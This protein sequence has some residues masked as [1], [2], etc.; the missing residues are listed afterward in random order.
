MKILIVDDEVVIRKGIAALLVK[1]NS[2][3]DL[4]GEAKNGKEAIALIEAEQPDLIFTDIRMPVMDGLSLMEYVSSHYPKIDKVLLT[5]YADFQY[6]QHAIRLGVMDYI[7]KP[8]TQESIDGVLSKALFKNPAQWAEQLDTDVVVE[9]SRHIAQLARQVLAEHAGEA[10]NNLEEW[11]SK[12]ERWGLSLTELK[13]LMGHFRLMYQSELHHL[14]QEPVRHTESR[15]PQS[16]QELFEQWNAQIQ[17]HIGTISLNRVPRNKKIVAQVLQEIEQQYG[18][19][20]LSIHTLA[21]RAGV[22]APYLSKMFREIMH[23]PLTHYISE[24]R[25]EKVKERLQS[26]MNTRISKISEECGFIDYPYF[27]KTF[28]KAYNVSP[29]EYREKH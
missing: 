9:M 19:I 26:D 29:Q 7:I 15:S 13:Q 23:Q 1:N 16:S 6:A 4:I 2:I 25:L 24:L 27:S 28:K 21:E 8:I 10:R 11:R 3:V 12:C 22:T 20:D 18:N 17:Q 14:G 5:G